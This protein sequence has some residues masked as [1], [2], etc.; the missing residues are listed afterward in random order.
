MNENE[1][2]SA[3]VAG[4]VAVE[5]PRLTREEQETIITACAADE[6]AEVYTS[7]PIYIRKMDKLVERDP[8]NYKVKAKNSYSVTYTMPKRLL[9]FRVPRVLTDEQKEAIAER[10]RRSRLDMAVDE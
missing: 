10:F 6:L 1:T 2:T 5:R 8:E 9:G 3:V 7:D 4:V